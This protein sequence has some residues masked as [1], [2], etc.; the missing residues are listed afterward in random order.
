PGPKPVVV[1]DGERR[2]VTLAVSIGMTVDQIAAVINMS[3]R[4][5]YRVFADDLANGHARRLLRS[6]ARLE[7]MAE[8]GNVSAAKFL[9]TLIM[10]RGGHPAGDQW[11]D[12]AASFVE[13]S[14]AEDNLAQNPEIRDLH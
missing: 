10:D 12:V 9:H 6:A 7:E 11:A 4:T 2:L 8:A 5:V 14:D 3:R 13:S 1:T